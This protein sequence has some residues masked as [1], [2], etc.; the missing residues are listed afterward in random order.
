MLACQDLTFCVGYTKKFSLTISSEKG[1]ETMR[2][3]RYIIV[4]QGNLHK[5]K[6]L[7]SEPV[8]GEVS[9][10]TRGRVWK[11]LEKNVAFHQNQGPVPVSS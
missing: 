5:A 8:V 6:R 3:L 10:G 7:R 11:K 9:R 2:A 1:S 4:Q